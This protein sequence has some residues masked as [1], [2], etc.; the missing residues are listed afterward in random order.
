[1][2]VQDTIGKALAIGALSK[3]KA[4]GETITLYHRGAAGVTLYVLVPKSPGGAVGE[5]DGA[6]VSEGRSESLGV[7][8]G[9]TGCQIATGIADPI[10]PGDYYNRRGRDY[11][12]IEVGAEDFGYSFKIKGVETKRVA[13]GAVGGA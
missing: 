6:H 9:Q 11:Q 10:S 13:T 1:M 5:S 7:P 12:I 2:S 3:A 4:L 8:T